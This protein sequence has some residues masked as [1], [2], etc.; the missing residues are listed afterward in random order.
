M[1]GMCIGSMYD[2]IRMVDDMMDNGLTVKD[3]TFEPDG[4]SICVVLS[5]DRKYRFTTF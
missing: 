5:N 2:L 4:E 3:F 1:C